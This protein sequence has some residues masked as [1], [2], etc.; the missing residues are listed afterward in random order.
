MTSPYSS[1]A[2]GAVP[3]WYRDPAGAPWERWWNGVTWSEETRPIPATYTVVPMRPP[4]TN[5]AATA[6]LTLGII[7]MFVNTLLVMSILA[8]VFSIVGLT[9]AS[10]LGRQGFGPVGQARCVWGLVL[11]ALGGLATVFLKF[12]IF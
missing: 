7:A 11:A 10:E 2:K 5:S 3:G 1:S 12:L 9:R 8:F 6:G 4:V